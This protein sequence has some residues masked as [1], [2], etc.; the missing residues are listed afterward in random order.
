M[1]EKGRFSLVIS[2]SSWAKWWR[3]I[4]RV[5]RIGC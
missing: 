5:E 3:Y 1:E 2:V 4:N